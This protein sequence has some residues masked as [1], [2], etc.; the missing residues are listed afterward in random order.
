MKLALLCF[1]IY[2]SIVVHVDIDV[3][4]EIA[5][6]ARLQLRLPLAWLI[7]L[8][9]YVSRILPLNCSGKEEL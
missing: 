6:E 4:Y 5:I 9:W 1:D 3:D 7:I 2:S 8:Q